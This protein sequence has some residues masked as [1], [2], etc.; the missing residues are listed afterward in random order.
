M[1]KS[2]SKKVIRRLSAAAILLLHVQIIDAYSNN[3]TK[4]HLLLFVHEILLPKM[5]HGNFHCPEKRIVSLFTKKIVIFT[6]C[7]GNFVSLE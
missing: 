2:N 3:K 1:G 5:C 7:E 4:S 6:R